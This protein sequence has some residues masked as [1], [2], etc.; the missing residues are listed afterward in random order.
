MKLLPELEYSFKEYMD[1][2]LEPVKTSLLL[3]SIKYK[4][5]DHL[6]TFETPEKVTEILGTHLINTTHFLNALASCKFIIKKD[7]K[8]KNSPKA[9]L[10]LVSDSEYYLGE[11][12]TFN[13]EWYR[14]A[15]ENLPQLIEKGPESYS[16]L[17]SESDEMWKNVT[18]IFE[19]FQKTG[20]AKNFAEKIIN[21]PEFKDFK[22][23]LDLGCSAGLIGMSVTAE[24][25]EMKCVLLDKP[26]V[27][28]ITK[29]IVEEYNMTDRVEVIAAD[30]LSEPIGEGYDLI[31]AS[32]TLYFAKNNIEEVTK[33]IFGALNPGGIFVSYHEG[34]FN[35]Q[36]QPSNLV[37][38]WIGSLLT[39]QNTSFQKGEIAAE[40]LKAGFSSVHSQTSHDI[41][42]DMEFDIA[43]KR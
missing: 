14:P 32:A 3:N 9:S 7:G 10:Y 40:M 29:E 16:D 17:K 35:E 30:Y 5:F 18:R 36:T 25:P 20:T 8:Y 15:A 6:K 26:M 34:F 1:L 12:I 13:Y 4:V 21:L 31:I 37:L 19:K 28:E 42:G 11:A 38:S 2:L 39:G 33:K 22:K 43:R 27:A 23:M 41:F 24:H